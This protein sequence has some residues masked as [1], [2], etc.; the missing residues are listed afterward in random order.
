MLEKHRRLMGEAGDE[1]CFKAL[2][3]I[4]PSTYPCDST[5][6]YLNMNQAIA[7]FIERIPMRDRYR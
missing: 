2:N 5:A 7:W 4:S 3:M 6:K 1:S